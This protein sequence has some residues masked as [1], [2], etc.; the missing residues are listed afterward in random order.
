MIPSYFL[1]T[2]RGKIEFILLIYRL[3]LFAILVCHFEVESH[4]TELI[5]VNLPRCRCMVYV[6]HYVV[7][8]VLRV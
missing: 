1:R 3:F 2:F 4:S 7:V 8:H 6:L 5:V